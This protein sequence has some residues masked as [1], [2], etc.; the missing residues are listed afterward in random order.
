MSSLRD[1]PSQT[2]VANI[3]ADDVSTNQPKHQA[4]LAGTQRT[5]LVWVGENYDQRT[6][7]VRSEQGGKK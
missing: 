7:A 6:V 1:Q 3:A 4:Y 5:A 2:Y